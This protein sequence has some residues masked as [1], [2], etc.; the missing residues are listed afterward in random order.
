MSYMKYDNI[1]YTQLNIVFDWC[2]NNLG[3]RPDCMTTCALCYI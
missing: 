1:D 2:E 3:Y